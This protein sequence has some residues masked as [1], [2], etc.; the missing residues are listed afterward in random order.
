MSPLDDELRGL[1]HARAGAVSPAPDPLA[2][3]ERRAVRMRRNR[4]A[5]TVAGAALAVT[6][7]AVGVPAL[8]SDHDRAGGT[9]F[10]T[11]GPS[12]SPAPSTAGRAAFDPQHPWSY[13]GDP[14]LVAAPRLAS[15][16]D[17]WSAHHPG[18]TVTP[19]FGQ[20]YEPSAKPEVVF[21]ATGGGEDRLGVATTTASGWGFEADVPLAAGSTVL[22]VPLPGDEV[23]RLLILADPG[24]GQIS[25]AADGLTFRALP[26]VGPGVAFTPLKGDTSKDAV[27]VLDGNGT[28]DD[29]VFFGPAP[30]PP[31]SMLTPPP[32]PSNLLTWLPRGTTPAPR[33]VTQAATA[34]AQA[35][36][37][38]EPDVQTRVLY[39]GRTADG[40]DYVLLQAWAKGSPA[41]LAGFE[42]DG[43]GGGIPFY[44]PVI[45]KEP[46]LIAYVVT[47]TQGRD[48]LVLLPRPGIGPIRYAASATAPLR[49]VASGRS[50]L[51]PVG[52]VDRDAKA[53]SDRLEVLDGD[54]MLVLYRGPVMPL[55]CG[56]S[57]CG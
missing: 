7:V 28:I 40:R 54:G 51:N 2:G 36:A 45:G 24:T 53:T 4:V 35:A 32:E 12:A 34:F 23:P 57:G 39:A 26:G 29:P 18:S 5:A 33:L 46:P 52:L 44:G 43:H 37:V 15:L 6:A 50:D 10:A 3:I 14:S 55:L 42:S 1:L 56:A 41:R 47:G 22:M 38:P 49:E 17:E 27:Q 16:Q 8:V 48:L 19:L 21:S 11:P 31:S 13:R 25:Y 20:V 30:D 9:Q